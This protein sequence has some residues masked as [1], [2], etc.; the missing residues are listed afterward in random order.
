M[1]SKVVLLLLFL[2]GV[3]G[4]Q[5]C[6]SSTLITDLSGFI[7]DA[8]G[9][10]N[11]RDGTNCTWIFQP[12]VGSTGFYE[13]TFL[14]FNTELNHD[15]VSLY[16]FDGTTRSLVERWSGVPFLPFS[17]FTV[18]PGAVVTFTSDGVTNRAGWR[19]HFELLP[20][21]CENRNFTGV[22]TD[23]IAVRRQQYVPNLDC[24]WIVNPLTPTSKIVLTFSAF[25]VD[26]SD[27]LTVYE[28]PAFR[29][30][31]TGNLIPSPV[32]G[33]AG[34]P[35]IIHFYSSPDAVAMGFALTFA[36]HF[37]AGAVELSGLSGSFDDGSGASDYTNGANCVWLID[38]YGQN[39]T[40][41]TFT[42]FDLVANQDYVIVFDGATESSAVLATL[43]GN[44]LPSPIIG[45]SG[46]AM[47]I[48]FYTD[49]GTTA[50]GFSA[51]FTRGPGYSVSSTTGSS[52]ATCSLSTPSACHCPGDAYECDL[53][54]DMLSS[55][56]IIQSQHT[57]YTG[58]ITLSNATPNVGWGPLEIHP[59]SPQQCWCGTTQVSCGTITLCPDGNYPS[60]SIVQTI[61]H[62]VGNTISSYTRPAGTMTYHPGHGHVHVDNW[63]S[64]TL[65]T[66]TADPNPLNWPIVGRGAKVS[67]CLVNLGDCTSNSGYCVVNGS[68]VTR[69]NIPNQGFGSISGCSR[70]QG[71]YTG[72]L[73]IYGQGLEG[74]EIT[75]P[76]PICNG[77]YYIVSITDP[78]N[79]FLE[80]DETNNWVVVPVDLTQ[81]TPG[82][83]TSGGVS[84]GG[85]TGVTTDPSEDVYCTAYHSTDT[86]RA[87]PEAVGAT[88]GPT[89]SSINVDLLGPVQSVRVLNVMGNHTFDG[90]IDFTLTKD[91]TGAY[92]T[93]SPAVCNNAQN[94][95]FSFDDAASTPI[96]NIPCPPTSGGS[97]LPVTPLSTFQGQEA[98]GTWTLTVFDRAAGD[99][100]TLDGWSLEICVMVT[101]NTISSTN[102]PIPIADVATSTSTLTLDSSSGPIYKVTGVDNL[103]GTHTYVGDLIFSLVSP[104]GT[105]NVL[106]SNLCGSADN[107]WFNFRDSATNPFTSSN[108]A[109]YNAGLTWRPTT[110]FAI[111]FAGQNPVGTWTMSIRDTA[112]QDTGT[113]QSWGLRACGVYVPPAPTTGVSQTTGSA[114]TA[115]TATTGTT[116][117]SGNC[118]IYPAGGL[119]MD[120][121]DVSTITPTIVISDSFTIG[122]VEVAVAGTH[123]FIGDLSFTLTSPAGTSVLFQNRACGGADNFDFIS[124]DFAS[125]AL[126]CGSQADHQTWLP[127]EALSAFNG[128][129]SSGTWTLSLQDHAGQ[130]VGVLTAW[131]L[132][133][134]ADTSVVTTGVAATT[135]TQ[136]G[137]QTTGTQT[138]T[139]T[140]GTQTGTQTTGTQ[141]GTQTTGTQ[142]GT[143]TTGTETGTQSTGTQTGTQTTEET[144]G[145]EGTSTGDGT[146]TGMEGTTT[147]Q[148]IGTTGDQ[149][150]SSASS[151]SVLFAF[152]LVLLF[153]AH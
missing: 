109:N 34:S 19:F 38:V 49:S 100:G 90:D 21:T 133:L 83:T 132:N 76:S 74:M 130:D 141:T 45:S 10:S 103:R 16:S 53:L 39:N 4:Q 115:T 143:Q 147:G 82:C 150:L 98:S 108:C 50:G 80:Y 136:T 27:Y 102:V 99:V 110:P 84:S 6:A 52:S 101:C 105:N 37:C 44:S 95:W 1:T 56:A 117:T 116:G 114:T 25:D 93:L 139:Q 120:I 35:F 113:L 3:T 122:R 32:N 91:S 112:G 134:C 125:T 86:P 123:T 36:N 72:Y 54:P 88:S 5:Y 63:A 152:L 128:Q 69:A 29:R 48:K 94:F 67:F 62:K 142:T 22:L 111:S 42:S 121:I 23:T 70:D 26:A 129:S 131:S 85:T 79:N 28:G 89:L 40:V 11:Y 14:D 97:Y 33:G 77:R 87:I 148:F 47:F 41:L 68:V 149:E 140:T 24:T 135:G 78:S 46:H 7:D 64:F 106:V 59:A 126:V 145:T 96:Q 73:D 138:G 57:E 65:R 81:Q 15:Y 71:I 119:P 17:A 151:V 12:P 104:Q 153:L 8:S 2:W 13:F 58:R 43:T 144:T 107:F 146:T 137:T 127:S 118:N 30:N 61:Y 75:F 124:S 9:G 60:E 31:M 66:A 20:P 92:C 18:T 51:T 55:A